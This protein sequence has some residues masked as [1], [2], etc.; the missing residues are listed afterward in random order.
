MR[1]RALV[2]DDDP[3]MCELIEDVLVS[4]GVE[5][6]AL[7]DS[8]Q[9]ADRLKKEK[10]DAVFL[11]VNMPSP[12]GIELARKMR[13]SGFNLKTPIIMIT[14]EEDPAVLERGFKAGANFFLF[15]PVNR[16]RILRV[17]Q[18]THGVIYQEKRR[19]QRVAVRCKVWIESNKQKLDGV[20]LDV[21][22]NGLL[23]QAADVFPV[24]LLV[25]VS[26]QLAVGTP[27][28][29]A[30]GRVVRVVGKNCM[31]IQLDGVK[32]KETERLQEFLLPLILAAMDE[33]PKNLPA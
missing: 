31:G 4:A 5:T 22:L 26:L 12:D 30:K 14:G 28:V 3:A 21:S 11:D 16:W 2:V 1:I 6:S 32:V 25:D 8:S 23:V 10:F 19:Y 15:K 29:C 33:D 20:T 17:I 13:D 27:A 24:G 9:A 18:A 7:T